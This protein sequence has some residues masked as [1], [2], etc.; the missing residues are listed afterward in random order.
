MGFFFVSDRLGTLLSPLKIVSSQ[1]MVYH[2]IATIYV[3]LDVGIKQ[4]RSNA[5]DC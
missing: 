2:S 1:F 4:E 5:E 3:G